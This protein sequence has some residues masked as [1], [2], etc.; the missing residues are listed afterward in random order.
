MSCLV[1]FSHL[2]WGFLVQRPQQLMSRLARDWRVLFIEE[3]LPDAAGPARLEVVPQGP[4]LLVV[5]PRTT[6]AGPAFGAAQMVELQ[7]LL[8]PWLREQAGPEHVAWFYTPMALPLL[9]ALQPRAVIYDCMAELAAW[10]DAPPELARREAELLQRADLVFTPGPTLYQ[11]KRSLHPAVHCLCNAVDVHHFAPAR[12]SLEHPQA[13]AAAA[14]HAGIGRPRLGYAG[15]VDERV[16]LRL[17]EQLADARAG[18]H[19]VMVGPVTGIAPAALPQRPNLHWLG[20]QPYER[21]PHLMAAWDVCLLPFVLNEATRSISPTKTLEYMA[22]EKPVVSTAVPD[23]AMLHGQA[24][25]IAPDA[26]AFVQAC[27]DALA[28]RG[29]ARG[30]RQSEMLTTVSR[31]SWDTSADTVRRFLAR[32]L[33]GRKPPRGAPRP[34]AARGLQVAP[35]R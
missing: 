33:E 22:A 14:L 21:L 27:G 5:R 6:A 16:D 29:R 12:L 26:E 3:P 23:V 24:V 34:P 7:P 11:A 25:R 20:L 32:E 30:E 17:L 18:W 15:A 2:R 35:V 4:N 1:V 31:F 28:E 8:E 10:R 13:H 9:A 19:V